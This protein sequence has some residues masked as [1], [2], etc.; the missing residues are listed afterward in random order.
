[1]QYLIKILTKSQSYKVSLLSLFLFI[2]MILEVFSLGIIIP[3]IAIVISS[4]NQLLTH[5]IIGPLFDNF[6]FLKENTLIYFSSFIIIVFSIKS[7][8][9]VYLNY[10][11][12]RFIS[13]IVKDVS[14]RLFELNIKKDLNHH[15]K[16]NSAE[17]IRNLQADIHFFTI[18]LDSVISLIIEIGLSVSVAL[19]LIYLEPF[20]SLMST[21]FLL[22]ILIIYY[23]T[24]RK[25]VS[26]YGI[27]HQNIELNKNRVIIESLNGIKDIKI[28]EKSIDFI[29]EF[30]RNTS[31]FVNINTRFT[32]LSQFPRYMLEIIAIWGVFILLFILKNQEVES[33]YIIETLGV[34]VAGI[35]RII[36]NI[37]KVIVSLQNLK[38]SKPFIQTIY[39]ELQ[40]NNLHIITKSNVSKIKSD[41]T[42]KNLSFSYDGD[43]NILNNV[44]LT[45]KKGEVIGICGESGSGKST[46]A[47]LL[48]GLQVPN[49][50]KI[51]IDGKDISKS[52]FRIGY[53]PQKVFFM[54]ASIKQN[55]SFDIN[56]VKIDS[57]KVLNCLK[58]VQLSSF[59]NSL[60]RGIETRIG[61]NGLLISG[62]QQQRI[63]IA[64]AFY[65]DPEILILDESTSSLD[66]NT[67]EEFLK[68]LE[69][70]KK[71]ITMIIISHKL[72]KVNFCDKKYEVKNSKLNLI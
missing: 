20:G 58:Q 28:L 5:P 55:V 34:F 43:K 37:N 24:I 40:N 6:P 3:L 29:K 72:D 35:F 4:E 9:L 16:R 15:L 38:Y 65:H 48:M 30:K 18:Y 63:G 14:D 69:G 47:D 23:N 44:S 50:G 22:I 46:L 11:K 45:I 13:G 19:L 33:V 66:E 49:E 60:E 26:V 10:R 53:V 32:T 56:D 41:I 2:G 57:D 7:A 8:Y 42:L 67:E 1:M 36:P 51:L 25:K 70:L 31:L 27:S 71:K 21:L 61:E 39:K 64:R 17:T 12:N 54:D 62:G 68:V 52:S 59:V